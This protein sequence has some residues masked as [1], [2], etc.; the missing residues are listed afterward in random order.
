MTW[1]STM[2]LISTIALFSPIA[3][4]FALRLASYKT[5]GALMFYYFIIFVYNLFAV[6]WITPPTRF[7]YYWGVTNNL[8]DAPLMLS[9][10]LYF[11]TSM[12]YT[13]RLKLIIGIFIVFEAITIA[14]TGYNVTANT[15]I[16]GPGILIV[17]GICMSSFIRQS[18]IAILHKKAAGK[19]FIAA[20]LLFA[21]GCYAIIYLMFYIF[22]FNHVEDTFLI[23]FLVTTISS[24]LLSTGIV[25]EQKRIR[26]LSELKVTR[27]E[28]SDMYGHETHRMQAATQ[29]RLDFDHE[30]WN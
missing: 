14:L 16:L 22:H 6:G 1:N 24:A 13:R 18:K 23:Y 15:I 11:S 9:F 19:A 28:L 30:Q 17:L 5:F 7:V 8:L 26:K 2:G 27:R 29:V 3:I 12:A 4:I 21:Y 20:A 10:L 25:I